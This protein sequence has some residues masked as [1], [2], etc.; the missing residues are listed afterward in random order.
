MKLNNLG[1]FGLIFTW[2]T[3][4]ALELSAQ[5]GGFSYLEFVENRGQWDS[6]ARFEAK[7]ANGTI[8]MN[9]KGFTILLEDTT[10][11]VRIG[12]LLHGDF[13][14]AGVT[15]PNFPSHPGG[16]WTTSGGGAAGGATGA[17]KAEVAGTA[18]A[19][20]ATTVPGQKQIL[21]PGNGGGGGV[22]GGAKNDPFLLHMHSYRVSFVGANDD[23]S[24]LPDKAV[25]SYNNYLIG[26]KKNWATHCKIYQG[27]LYQNMY[28]GIDVHYFTDA[29]TLKY[30]IVIHPGADPGQ[31]VLQY[32]GQ[33]KLSIRKG[34]VYIQTSV[35]MVQ[36]LE[37][38]SYQV[39]DAGRT[40]VACNYTLLGNNRIGFTVKNYSQGATLVID[41]TEVFCSFTGSKSD[42]WGYT[43]TFDGAGN[44]YLGGIVLNETEGCCT[45]GNGD[46]YPATVGAFQ[47]TYQGGDG[48]DGSYDYD[49]GI[50]KLSAS[51]ANRVFATYLGGSGDE[52]PHSMIVDNSGDLIVTGR[53]SSA[54]FPL[55]GV[56]GPYGVGG[57][58]D[59][60]ITKFN[61]G[62]DRV[63][64]AASGSAVLGRTGSIMNRNMW[65]KARMTFGLTMVMTAGARVIL[66][67]A[68]NVYLAAC[69]QSTDFPTT[70]GVFQPAP[71]W[72]WGPG[73][74]CAE[75]QPEPQPGPLQF[76]P[77]RQ[78]PGCRDGT[79]LESRW[80]TASGSPAVR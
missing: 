65:R 71:R 59:L 13:A 55:A 69:T 78:Q 9:R 36:E 42:N 37:P 76:L 1:R 47:T 52:Q 56:A 23:V 64:S 49:V 48:S 70:A 2:L 44:L 34:R 33:T 24:I 14:R 62:R 35:G 40:D 63:L 72:R 28:K 11:L 68:G 45:P 30:D 46:G 53:T 38:H 19:A 43:A 15:P 75:A 61:A 8:Y 74:C 66:D 4:T 57:G 7:L 22:S 20:A 29:G 39:S 21:P 80:T 3:L 73:W 79:G 32:D 12:E 31:V 5:S 77:G 54:N 10:D 6:A 27:I 58:Y 41:P 50:M 67:A 16:G 26:D 25:P 18:V 60:F 51:G 17:G